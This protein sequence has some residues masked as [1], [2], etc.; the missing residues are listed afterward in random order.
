MNWGDGKAILKLIE[1]IV[2]Q[3]GFGKLLSQGALRMAREFGRDEGEAAQ[4]KGMEMPM[5]EGRAFHG[6]AISYATGPR[7]ACHL[8]GDYYGVDLGGMVPELGIMSTGNRLSSVGTAEIA[9]KFQSLKDLY[10]ALTLCK[11]SPVPVPMLAETLIAITG[12]EYGPVDLLTAGDRSMN[13][14]R[15]ISNKL[16]LKRKDDKLPKICL[17]PH[18]E[19]ST[20]G[21][22]PDMDLLLKDYYQYRQ[23]DWETGRP[24]EKK[25]RELG[26]GFIADDLY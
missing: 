9:A 11:F 20:A 21:T 7:G 4:V 25:L 13:I 14:K 23:W 18:T 2:K 5:H 22:S 12:W 15:A 10:D 6:L 19:G 26:L 16:G 24:T 1:M 3:E 8:K 17:Q